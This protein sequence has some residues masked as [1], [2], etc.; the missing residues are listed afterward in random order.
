MDESSPK[1]SPKQN[2]TG[3]EKRLDSV[4]ISNAVEELVNGLK[5]YQRKKHEVMG[6]KE[7]EK[8]AGK[9]GSAMAVLKHLSVDTFED[10]EPFL[11]DYVNMFKQ[12]DQIPIRLLE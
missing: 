10:I 11:L 9:H 4:M 5:W 8:W 2:E 3:E 12:C 7:F 1:M 6:E